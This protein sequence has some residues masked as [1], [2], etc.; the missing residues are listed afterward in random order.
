MRTRGF[1]K[2]ELSGVVFT[3]SMWMIGQMMQNICLYTEKHFCMD[4]L[5]VQFHPSR[6]QVSIKVEA[7][8]HLFRYILSRKE[9]L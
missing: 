1:Q 8:A 5:R 4:G 2:S 3:G 7:S 9:K 6:S